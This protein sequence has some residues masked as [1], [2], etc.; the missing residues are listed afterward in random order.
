MREVRI[1]FAELQHGYWDELSIKFFLR[2][3]GFDTK[4]I[5]I[6]DIDYKECAVIYRQPETKDDYETFGIY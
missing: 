5:L 3:N 6:K 4:G 1:T 2:L